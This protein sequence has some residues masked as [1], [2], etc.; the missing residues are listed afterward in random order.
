MRIAPLAV[1]ATFVGAATVLTMMFSEL[2]RLAPGNDWIVI[3]ARVL[4]L[5]VIPLGAAISVWNA[6]VVLGGKRRWTAKL[7][8]IVLA[9]SCLAILWA[10]AAFHLI[11]FSANY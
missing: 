9:L 10:S 11:G 8:A 2:D 3:A 4:A 1:L 6:W 5:V 7:W